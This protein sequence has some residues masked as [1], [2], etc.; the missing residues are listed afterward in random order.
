MAQPSIAKGIIA[1]DIG[2]WLLSQAQRLRRI[3][4]AQHGVLVVLENK[5][6]DLSHFPVSARPARE[7]ALELP[8]RIGHVRERGTIAQGSGLAL[9]HRQIM[10]PV[11]DR[12]PAGMMRSIDDPAVLAQ[13]LPLGGD[14]DSIGVNPQA[15]RAVGERCRHAVAHALEAHE[16]G[17]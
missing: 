12:S 11:I 8:E 9:D 5:G 4:R 17:R 16:T 14:H 2:E 10:P 3:D 13:D 7:L 1:P 15:D 6:E